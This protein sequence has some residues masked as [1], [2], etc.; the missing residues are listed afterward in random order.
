MINL[1]QFKLNKFKILKD[2]ISFKI[3][4]KTII[5]ILKVYRKIDLNKL[6]L[7]GV[8]KSEVSIDDIKI[9]LEFYNKY[10]SRDNKIE[11]GDLI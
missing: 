2:L 3:S 4:Y 9:C 11:L 1:S 10:S 7:S 5:S 8:I 6:T